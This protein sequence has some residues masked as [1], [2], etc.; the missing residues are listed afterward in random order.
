[1]KPSE[2][3]T[4]TI[5]YDKVP[6]TLNPE[7]SFRGDFVMKFLQM[8][9]FLVGMLVMSTATVAADGTVKY[10]EWCSRAGDCLPLSSVEIESVRKDERAGWKTTGNWFAVMPAEPPQADL[11][12]VCRFWIPWQTPPQ[13]LF[14]MGEVDCQRLGVSLGAQALEGVVFQG[15]PIL[16]PAARSGE[17]PCGEDR[18]PVYRVTFGGDKTYRERLL[19]APD[20]IAALE[21]VGWSRQPQPLFCAA[22]S[23]GTYRWQEPVADEPVYPTVNEWRYEQIVIRGE[24]VD[25]VK[26]LVGQWSVDQGRGEVCSFYQCRPLD[27]TELGGPL[28]QESRSFESA[29]T[30]DENGWCPIVSRCEL[31]TGTPYRVWQA[32]QPNEPTYWLWGRRAPAAG[33]PPRYSPSAG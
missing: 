17:N 2:T 10:S 26:R 15:F 16:R 24:L 21:A 11:V 20:A 12:D 22:D 19:T 33:G 32:C 6:G 29:G 8:L 28:V 14:A 5:F 13:H 4:E 23:S 7:G 27:S 31:V 9:F 3:L 25:S 1:M 18:R 30:C